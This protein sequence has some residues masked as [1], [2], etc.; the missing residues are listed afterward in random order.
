MS[1]DLFV[2][3]AAL[4]VMLFLENVLPF[5]RNRIN[6]FSHGLK[7]LSLAALN[8][9]ISVAFVGMIVIVSFW[10]QA[11]R[12]GI[13]HWLDLLGVPGL[14]V[15]FLLYDN[16]M[17]FWHRLSHEVRVLWSFH[18]VHHTDTQMD[19]TTALR[20]HPAEI[21]ISNILNLGVIALIGMN[22]EQAVFY[23]S[24]LFIVILFHH[25]NIRL[26]GVLDE[27][28]KTMIVTPSMHRIHH[29]Q[30]KNETDSNYGSVFSFWDRIFRSFKV[31]CDIEAIRFGIGLPFDH[32]G[33]TIRGLLLMPL[34]IKR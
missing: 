34:G 14:V 1:A 5:D 9:L 20:F 6:K 32:Q 4:A 31:R 13:V 22:L 12:F 21:I 8:G 18:Q 3:S 29:S 30:V 23:K 17:Y 25:S 16:W 19:A 26:N 24:V 15:S 27:G 28:L 10:S 33:K 11:Y 7:N 2:G